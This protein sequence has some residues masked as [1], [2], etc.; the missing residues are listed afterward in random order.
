MSLAMTFQ[1]INIDNKKSDNR[2][3]NTEFHTPA[4]MAVS[5]WALVQN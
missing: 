5:R 4:L 1:A 3:N 2:R